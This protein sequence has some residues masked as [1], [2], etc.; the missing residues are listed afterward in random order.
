MNVEKVRLI[1][2]INFD[3]IIEKEGNKLHAIK[4]TEEVYKVFHFTG[5]WVVPKEYFED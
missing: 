3:N 4:I 1:K 5:W 2:D